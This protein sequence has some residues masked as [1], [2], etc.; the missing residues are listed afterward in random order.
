MFNYK[1]TEDEDVQKGVER[2]ERSR[3]EK[4]LIEL[5]KKK[6]IHNIK[7]PKSL[8]LIAREDDNVKQWNFSLEK[9]TSKD[10]FTTYLYDRN[11]INKPSMKY[12]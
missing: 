5:Q 6:G 9:K 8:E 3:I 1:I 12:D 7:S 4:K 10:T 11:S 2:M